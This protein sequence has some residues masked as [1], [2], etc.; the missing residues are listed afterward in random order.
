MNKLS[1]STMILCLFS[2]SLIHTHTMLLNNLVTTS[3]PYTYNIS[4][5]LFCFSLLI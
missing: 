2:L 5:V 4:G 1:L 3:S